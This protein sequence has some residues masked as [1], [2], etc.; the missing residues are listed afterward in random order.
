M[1]E[2][3]SA[4]TIEFGRRIR[5]ARQALGLSQEK[6]ADISGIHWSYWGQIER[7]VRNV[8]FSNILKISRALNVEPGALMDGLPDPDRPPAKPVSPRARPR[9]PKR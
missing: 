5:A 1:P 8:A 7:G 4:A 3:R 9:S 2:P 6:I